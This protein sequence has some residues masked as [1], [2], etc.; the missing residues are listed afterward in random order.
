[1]TMNM[2]ITAERMQRG[3][4]PPLR[5]AGASLL[6]IQLGSIRSSTAFSSRLS[7]LALEAAK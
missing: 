7:R 6:L 2:S 5:V 1:M 4:S 3:A